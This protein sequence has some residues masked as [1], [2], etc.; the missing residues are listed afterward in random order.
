MG[1]NSRNCSSA[2]LRRE[3]SVT[4]RAAV[5]LIVALAGCGHRLPPEITANPTVE[6][7]IVAVKVVGSKFRYFYR[8]ARRD[9]DING[10]PHQLEWNTAFEIELWNQVGAVTGPSKLSRR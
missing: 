9:H 10:L 2:R 5:T 6:V 8:I 7:E 1:T 4:R 3:D